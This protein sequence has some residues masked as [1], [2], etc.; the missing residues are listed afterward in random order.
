M[1]YNSGTYVVLTQ[2]PTNGVPAADPTK[3]TCNISD[4]SLNGIIKQHEDQTYPI[5]ITSI[6]GKLNGSGSSV[7]VFP[8]GMKSVGSVQDEI[9]VEGGVTKAIKR[10]SSCA[11]GN[12]TYNY[13][14]GNNNT[15][16]HYFQ[17]SKV[18]ND[19]LYNA[20]T[21]SGSSI[22]IKCPIYITTGAVKMYQSSA[23][24]MYIG[25]SDAGRLRIRDDR[26]SD[27]TLFKNYLLN[28]NIVIN[29]QLET[30]QEY[31]L[32]NF[33]LPLDIK[34][35][36]GGTEEIISTDTTSVGPTL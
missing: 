18:S 12:L 36:R 23:P 4:T 16:Y 28:N 8:D 30:P 7:V 10:I 2:Y 1:T 26:Y 6:T 35:E 5:P 27:S 31:I 19:I 33:S 14:S 34:V 13:Q 22:T 25:L 17:S 32:D 9:I 15:D 24:D 11:I 29:Y 20:D 3:I 21:H